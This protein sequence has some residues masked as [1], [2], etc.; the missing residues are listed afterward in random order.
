MLERFTERARRSVVLGQE[1]LRLLQHSYYG[2]EH[3]LLGLIREGSGGAARALSALDITL[4]AVRGQVTQ[5]IGRGSFT[6]SG[7][8]PFTPG[9]KHALE[10]S[11][12]ESLAL[13]HAHIGTGHILLG[14][15]HEDTGAAAQILVRL[16][17]GL[18]SVREQ[19]LLV[20]PGEDTGDP[21]RGHGGRPGNDAT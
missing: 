17:A 18:D 7:H 11:L 15:I 8:I 13:G 10:R 16:G 19:V 6:S 9:A 2:P 21:P 14:L 3:L 5:I 20:L 1:E 4:A 12:P